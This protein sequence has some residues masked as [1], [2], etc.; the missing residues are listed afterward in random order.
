MIPETR[1]KIS[2]NK[3]EVASGEF[4]LQIE[5]VEIN[6]EIIGAIA[7][8]LYERLK[9]RIK[10]EIPDL[11]TYANFLG[12]AE[13]YMSENGIP[14]SPVTRTLYAKAIRDDFM[15][16]LDDVIY[17]DDSDNSIR[18]SPYITALENGDFYRPAMGFLTK[19]IQTWLD[20]MYKE[21]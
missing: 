8:P 4:Y 19:C 11:L 17:Y 1:K 9:K 10:E 3:N 2:N 15:K 18:I 14:Y 20:D 13:I 5:Y 7:K 12:E 21:V 6:D 16:Q